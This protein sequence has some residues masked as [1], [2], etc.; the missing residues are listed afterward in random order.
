MHGSVWSLETHIL[1]PVTRLELEVELS[2]T[3]Y[4]YSSTALIPRFE[5]EK[6]KIKSRDLERSR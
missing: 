3:G 1:R 4:A 5:S 2:D 6:T